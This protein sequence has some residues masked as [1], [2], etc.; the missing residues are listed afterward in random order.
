ML[1]ESIKKLRPDAEDKPLNILE[2]SE[3]RDY[4]NIKL[5]PVQKFIFKLMYGIP[6]SE[7]ISDD[8]IVI[9]DE[10]NE[11]IIHTFT[12]ELQFLDFLY[13]TKRI[14][15]KNISNP[16]ETLFFLGRRGTKTTMISIVTSYT[17]YLLLRNKCPQDYLK[18]LRQS[19]IGVAVVSN[20]KGNAS[21]QLREIANMVYGSKW[22]APFIVSKEPSQEGFFLRTR[23][24]IENK[25]WSK[26]GKLLVS[27]FAASPSV[28]GASNMVVIMDEFAHFI[29]SDKST[30]SEPLDEKLY[31]ALTPSVSGFTT[32]EG[33]A[34][35][36]I[37]I[38]TSPNGKRG[39]SWK[40]YEMSFDDDSVLML[41]MPSNWVNPRLAPKVIKKAYEKSESVCSQEYWAMFVGTKS[42]FIK[43][44]DKLSICEDVSLPNRPQGSN[45]K[46]YY[47]AID[48]ALSSD[49]FAIAV[50]HYE[51]NYKR[52]LSDS[53]NNLH[54]PETD[55]VYVI[56]YVYSYVPSGDESLDIDDMIA[57]I[58][59]IFKKFKIVKGG[60]DQWSKEFFEREFKRVGVFKKM[61]LMFADQRMNSEWAKT[62]K[63]RINKGD[64]VWSPFTENDDGITF[65]GEI[66]GLVE[67]IAGKFI[68]VEAG[69]TGHDDRFS[70]VIK[71]LYLCYGD[72]NKHVQTPI[73][74]RAKANS[75][76]NKRV[77]N[78]LINRSVKKGKRIV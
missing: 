60:Y 71:A 19:E 37:F 12:S 2:F 41:H 70:A 44:A 29:D 20:N 42:S 46:R 24:E 9:R 35:G 31:D 16:M 58:K 23:E 10:F 34:L 3:H 22:F 69:G 32:D 27:V 48:Q 75:A 52:V 38:A 43:S 67:K 15:S 55:G 13:E 62:F 51:P 14:N 36:K 65:S 76:Q 49:N 30:K 28:R 25:D 77:T 78:N 57:E 47:M 59:M 6:L 33:D 53:N 40:K 7:D 56:D 54:I 4:L 1:A 72:P 73:S 74:V 11:H 66:E 21:R 61:E 50:V 45:T 18:I 64:I 63:Q 39:E 26:I 5:Y 8:P 68:K 17:L